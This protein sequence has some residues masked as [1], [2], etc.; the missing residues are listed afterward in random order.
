MIQDIANQIVQTMD[1]YKSI[2]EFIVDIFNYQRHMPDNSYLVLKTHV[3]RAYHDPSYR[4]PFDSNV[5]IDGDKEYFLTTDGRTVYL[6][7]SY[8][9]ARDPF[10]SD[11]YV[12]VD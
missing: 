7:Q 12:L 9:N 5:W 11:T 4:L 8:L 10:K 2:D 3:M 1:D 6:E